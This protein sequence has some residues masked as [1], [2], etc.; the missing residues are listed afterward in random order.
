MSLWG[1]MLSLSHIDCNV[2]VILITDSFWSWR[3]FLPRCK[4]QSLLCPSCICSAPRQV[5]SIVVLAIIH[6]EDFC[7]LP[8]SLNAKGPQ[9]LALHTVSYAWRPLKSVAGNIKGTLS[10]WSSLRSFRNPSLC[11]TRS[12]HVGIAS[13]CRMTSSHDI[14]RIISFLA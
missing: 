4:S 10:S 14:S 12:T 6:K 7:R 5:R 9:G 8:E 2:D 11:A 3:C 13:T 1:F